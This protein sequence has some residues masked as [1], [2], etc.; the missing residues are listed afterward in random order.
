MAVV[1]AGCAS[2][3]EQCTV[4]VEMVAGSN[5]YT[6]SVANGVTS[7]SAQGR[8]AKGYRIFTGIPLILNYQPALQL[9]RKRCCFYAHQ[10]LTTATWQGVTC[11]GLGCRLLLQDLP[12]RELDE[13]MMIDLRPS[14][15][16]TSMKS[17]PC[18]SHREPSAPQLV[19]Q[20][21][22]ESSSS[23][24]TGIT[25]SVIAGAGML[26]ALALKGMMSEGGSSSSGGKLAVFGAAAAI[27]AG[28]AG[29]I[30][31][32]DENLSN[33]HVAGSRE[34][35]AHCRQQQQQQQTKVAVSGTAHLDGRVPNRSRTSDEVAI[36]GGDEIPLRFLDPITF[37]VITALR[38]ISASLF[39]IITFESA[40]SH[41]SCGLL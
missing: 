19:S 12:F 25:A 31:A 22:S 28:V 23:E 41:R 2:P 32:A 5:V 30:F 8:A 16:S 34:H 3:G 20:K 6:G 33:D 26:G 18:F 11:N 21:N 9:Q 24:S 14:D 36:S 37:E 38:F 17:D 27:V 15:S 35:D 4:F 13:E 10:S 40:A 29:V 39:Y 1:H 7:S